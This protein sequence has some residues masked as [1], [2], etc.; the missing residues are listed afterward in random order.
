LTI[1]ENRGLAYPRL[2]EVVMDRRTSTGVGMIAIFALA[3]LGAASAQATATAG[4]VC[5]SVSASGLTYKWSV[6][7]NVTCSQAKPWLLKFLVER[8]TPA[9]KLTF[10]DGPKGFH[11]SAFA[12]AKGRPSAGGCET[13]TPAFPKNGFQWFG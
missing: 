3:G 8:G 2:R 1:A 4:S 9:A 10:K 13:G 12:D 6:I 7:S 5:E 11:C